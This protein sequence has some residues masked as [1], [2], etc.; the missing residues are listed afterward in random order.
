MAITSLLEKQNS[1]LLRRKN[2]DSL[3]AFVWTTK[4]RL[5]WSYFEGSI[6]KE[7][8]IYWDRILKV[9]DFESTKEV[10]KSTVFSPKLLTT[11]VE[12]LLAKRCFSVTYG[13]QSDPFT[14]YF[15]CPT[16]SLA[17]SWIETCYMYI[18]Q[19]EL[20][21]ARIVRRESTVLGG[22]EQ[23]VSAPPSTMFSRGK[24]LSAPAMLF[25]LVMA[26]SIVTPATFLL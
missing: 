8:F 10:L 24:F 2:S 1:L 19:Q 16:Q 23:P 3:Y 12:T 21:K 14:I 18:N 17:E 11:D 6:Q 26:M 25:S 13:K 7:G 9:L 15:E 5:C 20:N 4:K 22:G